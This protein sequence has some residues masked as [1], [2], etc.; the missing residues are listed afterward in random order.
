MS[1]ID[2]SHIAYYGKPIV[3]LTKDELINALEELAGAIHDCA[4][5][6]NRCSEIIKVAT[7]LERSE[8]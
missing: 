2:A 4:V 5:K 6:N 3:S 8:D 7:K 1:K